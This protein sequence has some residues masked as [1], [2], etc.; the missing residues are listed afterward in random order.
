MT[1][2]LY[3]AVRPD[4]KDFHTGKI[5][6]LAEGII[7]H[8]LKGGR[9][10]T[11]AEFYLSVSVTPTDCTGFSWL[12]RLLEVEAVGDVWTPHSGSLPNKRAVKA[13]RVV[14]ELDAKLLLGPQAEELI[15]LVARAR[16]LTYEEAQ[17]LA[18]AWAA[19]WDAA[20]DAA[21]A[22]VVRDRIGSDGFTQEYYDILSGPWRR[23]IGKIHADDVDLMLVVTK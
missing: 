21:W 16:A 19:A 1:E 6:Y 18:A 5:D 11:D 13:L 4:G 20:R 15:V 10:R 8:P 9:N 14:R 17:S 2:T 23:T 12:A 22:L 7:E 3:K